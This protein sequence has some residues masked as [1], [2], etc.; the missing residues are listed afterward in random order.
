MPKFR[1]KSVVVEAWQ[2]PPLGTDPD[3]E[4]GDWIVKGAHDEYYHFKQD[5]FAE[6]YE[7][8]LEE[9]PYNQDAVKDAFEVIKAAMIADSP[10]QPGSY[11]HSWHCNIAMMCYDAIREHDVTSL[12]LLSIDHEDAI[13][14]GNDAATRFMK[15]CFD[16]DTKAED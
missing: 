10:E 11:A 6:T 15:L 5:F 14:I 13:K 3:L 4:P 2:L 9:H 7:P 12:G 16:V 1:K 8:V